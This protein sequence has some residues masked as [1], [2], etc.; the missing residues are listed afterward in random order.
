MYTGKNTIFV[1]LKQRLHFSII[2]R[3]FKN[4]VART[5]ETSNETLIHFEL[6]RIEVFALSM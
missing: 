4:I 1:L 5:T 3:V 6:N 2:L